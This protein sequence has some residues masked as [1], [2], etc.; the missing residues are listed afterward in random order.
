[1]KQFMKKLSALGLSLALAAVTFAACGGGGGVQGGAAGAPASGSGGAATSGAAATGDGAVV[2]G[3][4][5]RMGISGTPDLDPAIASTNS[6]TTAVASLYDGLVFPAADG[7]VEPRLAE[8]WEV[9][10]DGLTYTFKLKQGVKFHDGSE[11]KANDVK[12]S[13]DRVIA[14]GEGYAYLYAG[15]VDNVEVLGDY[16]VAFHLTKPYGPFVSSLVRFFVL[17]EAMVSANFDAAGPYGENGDYGKTWLVTHDAGTGAYKA[18]ELVQQDYFHAEKFDDWF[19]GWTGREN[20]PTAFRQLAVPEPATV[21]TMMNNREMEMT[22]MW[23]SSE[24]LAAMEQFEGVTIAKY[25]T[26]LEQNMY[27]NT[28]KAP[29]DDIN[30]RKGVAC[31]FDY[32]SI[33]K[34]IFV[35]S[36]KAQGPVAAGVTGSVATNVMKYDVEKAKEYFAQSKYA[37]QLG[38]YPLEMLVNSDVADLEKVA[39]LFQAAA[40]EVGIT[41]EISKAPWVSIIDRVATEESTPHMLSINSAPAFN[42]AGIYLET[43]YSTKTMGTWENCEWLNNAELDSMIAE[44]LGTVD[45]KERLAEYGNIQNYIVDELYPTAYLCD[46]TERIAYQSSYVSWPFVEEYKG[47]GVPSTLIGF[48]QIVAD[49]SIFPDR[50]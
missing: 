42:E 12:F 20:A 41:V 44:S 24:N 50:K 40:A 1:M 48:S 2:S 17:S 4:T 13:M 33:I 26:F 31:L 10:D 9:S 46:L 22:D 45:E 25:S 15:I 38:D 16:E 5:L 30:F 49:I 11:M 32:D 28:K 19:M 8:S 21:R 34:D 14:I 23:Q 36:E 29:M 18:T 3:T 43:R 35:D 7:S 39:L 6:S 37:D 47:D 27:M